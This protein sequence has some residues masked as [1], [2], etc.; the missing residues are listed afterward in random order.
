M[1]DLDMHSK[2]DMSWR[3]PFVVHINIESLKRG[4]ERR[5]FYLLCICTSFR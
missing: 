4:F 3:L 2:A 5:Y 1:L